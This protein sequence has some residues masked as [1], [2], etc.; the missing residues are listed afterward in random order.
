LEVRNDKV[1]IMTITDD[2]MRAVANLCNKAILVEYDVI[3]SYPKII[4]HITNFEKI[5][6]DLLIHDIEILGKDSLGHYKIMDTLITRLGYEST[7]QAGVLPR[8][9]GVLDVMENQLIKERLARDT[10]LEAK[11]VVL[12]NKKKVRVRE[13]FGKIIRV[14]DGIGEDIMTADEIVNSLDRLIMDEER[15]ARLVEDSIAT[16]TMYLKR[17]SR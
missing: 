13:F 17:M 14:R 16:L 5:K 10:Y 6:D 9:V 2:A 15:H 4:D 11:K 8:I 12:N 3:F 7:W 1:D